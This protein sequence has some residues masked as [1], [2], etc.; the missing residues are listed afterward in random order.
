[1]KIIKGTLNFKSKRN[2]VV[3]LGKFDGIHR[4]H[5][6]LIDRVLQ[7][8]DKNVVRTVCAFETAPVSL[9]AKKERRQMLENMGVDLLVEC[10]FT[11]DLICMMPETFVKKILVKQLKAVHVVV[12]ADY[13]FG[14]RRS[15]NVD[16]LIELGRKYGFTVEIVRKV[17]DIEDKVS[18]S[19]IR[20]ELSVG[21]MERV[22]EL[23][24]YE[25]FITG[26]VIHG[27]KMG[28][29][30]GIPTTNL[31]PQPGKLLPPNGVYITRTTIGK[32][33]YM[34]MTNIGCK[35]TVNGSFIGVET[36]LFDCSGDLYGKKEK[37]R[38]LQYVRPEQKFANI[39]ELKVQIMKDK[40]QI[41]SYI[42]KNIRAY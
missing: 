23:L 35:P 20:K 12:G 13:H 32:K 37:V 42:A 21:N 14:Y 40:E 17:L 7:Y 5:K 36:H 30:F 15:G 1:M 2:T 41:E 22:N 29:A 16:T 19:T 4:G 28:T 38:D 26:E 3:T 6:A 18:S 24:G 39:S 25:Y 27:D 9:L 10:P 31:I 34:G 8:G 11:A 33:T